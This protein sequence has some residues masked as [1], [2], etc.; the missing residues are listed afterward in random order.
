MTYR[1]RTRSEA[2]EDDEAS[3]D[4]EASGSKTA[5]RDPDKKDERAEGAGP[6][7]QGQE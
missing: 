3:P 7:R 5:D 4:A 1:G 6:A 2:P